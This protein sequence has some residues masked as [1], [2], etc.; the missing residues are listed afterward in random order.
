M[1]ESY[2]GLIPQIPTMSGE[3][4]NWQNL[5]G[6]TLY[7]MSGWPDLFNPQLT[8]RSH[9]GV[10]LRVNPANPDHVGRSGKL[11]KSSGTDFIYYV[12]VARLVQPAVN[13]P[14]PCG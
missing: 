3:A 10:L 6:L 12:G 2:C 9:A 7:I 5:P 4:G 8:I 13:D 11:A 14:Q 1:R